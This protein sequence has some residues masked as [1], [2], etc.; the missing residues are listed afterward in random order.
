M[1][2]RIAYTAA[3][4]FCPTKNTKDTQHFIATKTGKEAK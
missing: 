2:N 1:K 4:A 3:T